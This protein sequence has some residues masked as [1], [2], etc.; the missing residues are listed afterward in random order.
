MRVSSSTGAHPQTRLRSPNAGVRV[1]ARIPRRPGPVIRRSVVDEPVARGTPGRTV[2]GNRTSPG[3]FYTPTRAGVPRPPSAR[4]IPSA[5][6]HAH[7]GACAFTSIPVACEL[8]AHGHGRTCSAAHEAATRPGATGRPMRAC[9]M[10]A[11]PASVGHDRWDTRAEGCGVQ[12]RAVIYPA[13]V[14]KAS[15]NEA[16]MAQ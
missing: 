2:S 3:V 1:H 6:A 9:T 7:C 4:P 16:V 15:R 8:D 12:N 11:P 14:P 5:G 13:P 10:R